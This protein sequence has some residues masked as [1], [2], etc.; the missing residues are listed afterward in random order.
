V[1]EAV[2]IAI[3]F[4]LLYSAFQHGY[5]GSVFYICGF[6]GLLCVAHAHDGLYQALR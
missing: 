5:I 3:G 2:I 1:I 4:A 6:L